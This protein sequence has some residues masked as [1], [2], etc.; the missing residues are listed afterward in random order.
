MLRILIA[1]VTVFA[2][3]LPVSAKPGIKNKCF[4]WNQDGSKRYYRCALD[5]TE[6]EEAQAYE[7]MK[8]NRK[9]EPTTQKCA[10]VKG[11]LVCKD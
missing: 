9:P 2:L 8:A 1:I 6:A 4:N 3:T 5:P 11:E 10:M 7:K